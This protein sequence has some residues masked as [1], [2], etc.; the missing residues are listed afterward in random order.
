MRRYYAEN[1]SYREATKARAKAHAEKQKA[2]DPAAFF[3]RKAAHAAAYRERQGDRYKEMKARHARDARK[4]AR[5]FV[6]HLKA[7][8]PCADCGE[9]FPA[10]CMDFDHLSDKETTI[11]KLVASGAAPKRLMKEISKCEIVC[12]CCHRLR[13]VDRLKKEGIDMEEAL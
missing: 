11:A 8:T 13:T 2:D 9:F 6:V 3:A 5:E 7:S 12:A 1:E 10:V 4:R